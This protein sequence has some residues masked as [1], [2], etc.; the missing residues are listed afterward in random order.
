V[1]KSA[2]PKPES[3]T[4][5][6]PHVRTALVDDAPV[7]ADAVRALLVEVGGAPPDVAAMEAA[8]CTAITDEDAGIVLV[9]GAADA[10]VGVLAASWVDAIHAGGP[11]ALLQDLWVAPSWRS[12]GVGAQL[13]TALSSRAASLGI[14]RIEVGI[15]REVFAGLDATR[16]FYEAN[17][18][19]TVGARMRRT[20]AA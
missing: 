19:S 2:H 13:V 10:V 14:A 16:R 4:A 15:P 6:R 1:N 18:F 9:A 3:S 11:Y 8:A 5:S 12:S 7:V 17:G 20:V